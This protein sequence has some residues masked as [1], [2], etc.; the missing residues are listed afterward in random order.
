[1]NMQALMRQAQQMQ[2][3]V[4]KSKKEIDEMEFEG[5]SALVA[6]KINGAKQVLSVKIEND[7]DVKEDLSILEDMIVIAFNDALKQVDAVTNAKMGK[8]SSAM[9]GLF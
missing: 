7:N 4:L 2:Q 1:M 9:P 5:K 8:Y 6:V 3:D